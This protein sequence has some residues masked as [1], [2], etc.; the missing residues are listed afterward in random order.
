MHIQSL[1]PGF[2]RL[3][4]VAAVM[5]TAACG[6]ASGG[7]QTPTA[8]VA[9]EPE[10]QWYHPVLYE[11][12]VPVTEMDSFVDVVIRGE[13]MT[14]T[15]GDYPRADGQQERWAV[16]EIEVV[17]AIKG[18]SGQSVTVYGRLNCLEPESEYYFLLEDRTEVKNAPAEYVMSS[19]AVFR[20]AEGRITDTHPDN[21]QY[22]GMDSSD[23][24]DVLAAE[25]VEPER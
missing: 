4:V 18:A 1:V 17:E 24:R 7:G 16:Y 25:F 5:L 9:G 12:P 3:Q 15:V 21:G 22:A 11:M 8:R 23:F 2:V 13:V 10:C 6:T 20:V 19:R 14:R